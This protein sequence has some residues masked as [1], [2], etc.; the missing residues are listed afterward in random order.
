LITEEQAIENRNYI[1]VTFLKCL[2]KLIKLLYIPRGIILD[3]KGKRSYTTVLLVPTHAFWMP[4]FLIVE[5]AF[6]KKK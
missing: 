6:W 5:V 1:K 3:D 4:A 2:V